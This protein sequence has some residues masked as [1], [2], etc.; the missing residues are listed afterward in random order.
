MIEIEKIDP[1]L[2]RKVVAILKTV[3]PD[4][5][6]NL[7]K[8][9]RTEL[10]PFATRIASSVPQIAPLSGMAHQGAKGYAPP[11]AKVSFTPGGGS[12]TKARLLAITLDS[13]QGGFQIAELAGSRTKGQTATGRAMIRG[14]QA[15]YPLVPK[16][17]GRFAWR[18]FLKSAPEIQKRAENIINNKLKEIERQL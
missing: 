5:I 12:K 7:R 8:E 18:A 3:E 13:P 6:T 16:R 14:L 11:R 17:G 10:Q 15:R 2:L 4:V 9:L 1:A